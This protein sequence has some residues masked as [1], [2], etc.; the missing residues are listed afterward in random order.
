MKKSYFYLF[1]ITTIFLSLAN[2]LRA[3]ITA[4]DGTAFSFIAKDASGQTITN[5]TAN[6]I[7]RFRA[8]SATGS[9]F[10]QEN[11]SMPI[12]VDG[13]VSGVI[14]QGSATLGVFTSIDWTA[15]DVYLDLELNGVQQGTMKFYAVPYAQYAKVADI[16]TSV[17]NKEIVLVNQANHQTVLVNDNDIVKIDGVINLSGNYLNKLEKKNLT[18][19]GGEFIGTGINSSEIEIATNSVVITNM[20]FRNLELDV[21]SQSTFIN[22]TFENVTSRGGHS[23]FI[24][25]T[26]LGT[27]DL[28][29]YSTITTSIINNATFSSSFQSIENSTI[30]NSTFNNRIY[31]VVNNRIDDSI[32]D[33][34]WIVS[35]NLVYDTYIKTQFIF[36]NNNCTHTTLEYILGNL[37]TINGNIFDDPYSTQSQIITISHTT[38]AVQ[39]IIISNNHFL[40]TTG[41]SQFIHITGN[42]TGGLGFYATTQISNNSFTKATRAIVINSITG[43][44]RNLITGN[45]TNN[46]TNGLGVLNGGINI[47]NNNH[48]F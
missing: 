26:F 45:I 32:F 34:T 3:Q 35:N 15:Q 17:V 27:L 19:S 36:S 33:E 12:P 10:Y 25:C 20:I 40:G 47:V 4:F 9:I 30:D 41:L 42:Y 14:G 37:M 38:T 1:L 5:Q 18:I 7:I 24:N 39:K 31:R 2:T 48:N 6:V 13:V 11:N 29:S 16:A 28:G 21:P 43:N 46:V 8:N 23:K 44:V 22:C